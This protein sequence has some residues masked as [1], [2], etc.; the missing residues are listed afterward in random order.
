MEELVF[1]LGKGGMVRLDKRPALP[2]GTR[3][4]YHW[5]AGNTTDY[6][7]LDDETGRAA[8]ADYAEDWPDNM[9]R[10]NERFMEPSDEYDYRPGPFVTLDERARHIRDAFGIGIYYTDDVVSEEVC[11]AAERSAL[12]AEQVIKERKEM[13]AQAWD[14][15][16]EECRAKWGGIL[17]EHPAYGKETTDNVRAYLRHLFPGERYSV[18]KDGYDKAYV[19]WKDGRSEAEVQKVLDIWQTGHSDP[20]GDYWDDTDSAFTSLYGG[21]SYGVDADRTLT[22]EGERR[23]AD[24]LRARFPEIPEEGR[25]LEAWR[26][27]RLGDVLDYF[28]I[29]HR[30]DLHLDYL[31]IDS[32]LYYAKRRISLEAPSK[33]AP[34]GEADAPKGGDVTVEEYSEKAIVVRGDTRPLADVLKDLGGRFNARLQG[35]AG[36]IFSK[37]KEDEVRQALGIA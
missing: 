33:E 23:I 26:Y 35:G 24:D 2:R 5:Y 10:I 11:L 13:E 30:Y 37:R 25:T 21:F 9:E 17:K 14:K 12:H 31:S 27:D 29:E 18:R 34:K 20:S 16:L 4:I 28:G 7:L 6:I 15:A 32:L 8:L 1:T 19:S 22:E 3:L 36:W